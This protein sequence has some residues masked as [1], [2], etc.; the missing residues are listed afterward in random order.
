MGLGYYSDILQL[1]TII[2]KHKSVIIITRTVAIGYLA[3]V[4]EHV[5]WVCMYNECT[6]LTVLTGM[7]IDLLLQKEKGLGLELQTIWKGYK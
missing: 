4:L 3:I 6:W 1:L 7:T 2:N 5:S